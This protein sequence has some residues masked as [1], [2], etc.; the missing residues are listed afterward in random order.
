MK[1]KVLPLT[2]DL[3]GALEDLF[4]TSGPC[5]RCWCMYW[6][7]GAAYRERPGQKNKAAFR[8][9]VKKGP[10]P[11]LLAFD[12]ETAVGWCQVTPRR[13]LAWLDREWRLRRVDDV[14]VWS[15]SCFYVRKGYRKQGITPT[16][17]AAAVRLAKRAR[18]IRS[19]S[20]AGL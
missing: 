6:R 11:G 10:P 20:L 18:A 16:L 4:A 12:G 3:W 9:I 8:A 17:I 5:S 13:D 15:L 7:I 2:P 19:R 1:L 14:P